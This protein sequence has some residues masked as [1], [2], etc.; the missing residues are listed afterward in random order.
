MLYKVLQS[1]R[2]PSS[3]ALLLY[4]L[5]AKL[6]FQGHARHPYEPVAV[7]LAW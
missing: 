1:E 7:L 3:L 5:P 6:P 2:T 4:R